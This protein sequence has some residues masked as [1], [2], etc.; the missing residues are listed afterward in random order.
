LLR[1][2]LKPYVYMEKVELKKKLEAENDVLEDEKKAVMKQIDAEQGNMSQYHE[3]QA[4]LSAQKA[5][6][7]VELT[8]AQTTLSRLEKER[9]Y[10]ANDKKVK[11]R[12]LAM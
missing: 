5:D 8:E 11:S 7:E 1:R 2:L 12:R 9:V 10:A 4:K 6:L 3:K